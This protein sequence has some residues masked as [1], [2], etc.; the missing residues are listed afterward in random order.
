MICRTIALCLAAAPGVLAAPFTVNVAPLDGTGSCGRTTGLAS[1]LTPVAHAGSFTHINDGNP[2]TRVDTWAND[3]ADTHSAASVV[4]PLPRPD[5]LYSVE[6]TMACFADGG[7]FGPS[8][9]PGTGALLTAAHL[10]APVLQTST[11]GGVTWTTAATTDDYLAAVTGHSTGHST[12]GGAFPNPHPVT[13]R[14]DLN[15]PLTGINAVRLIGQH[16]GDPTAYLGI[17]EMVINAGPDK[18]N[19]GDTMEDAWEEIY[20]NP[21][22]LSQGS[23]F[24]EDAIP[25]EI[26]FRWNT[27][28]ASTD[29]DGDG[30]NDKSEITSGASSPVLAD[31]DGDSLPDGDELL[32]H[33]TNPRL[34][35]TD[36]DGLSDSDEVN[37]HLTS[38]TDT[39]TD[40]DGFTDHEEVCVFGTLPAV[41]DTDGDGFPDGLEYNG[42]SFLQPELFPGN[43]ARAG[44]AVL[45][46]N[47]AID[48]DHGTAV[49]NG[50][51]A[52]HV[53]DGD[54]NT[55]VNTGSTPSLT[56]YSYVG[57]TWPSAW[58]RPIARA[59]VHFA[60]ALDG[61]WFGPNALAPAPGSELSPAYLTEP[62]VQFTTDG[63][64]WQTYTGTV[65]SS[66]LSRL[67]GFAVPLGAIPVAREADFVFYPPISG[68]R[69][70][71]LIGRE[72]GTGNDG[73]LGVFEMQ[74]QD[75][76][77][78][79]ADFP[80][81]TDSDGDGTRDSEE[82]A[83]GTPIL[84]AAVNAGTYALADS[85]TAFSGVQGQNGW[86]YGY[87][88]YPAG[89]SADYHPVTGFIPFAGGSDVPV[90]Y[91]VASINNH[92]QHWNPFSGRW[93]LSSPATPGGEFAPWV[94]IDWTLA[95]PGSSNQFPQHYPA[96]WGKEL[97]VVRRWTAP[98]SIGGPTPVTIVYRSQTSN[99]T[100]T[101]GVTGALYINGILRDHVTLSAAGGDAAVRR[102]PTILQ[103]GDLV[104]LVLTPEGPDGDRR[105][106][107]DLTYHWMRI[108][109]STP[110][111]PPFRPHG[112][113]F[114]H[115]G[116]PDTDA[117]GLP[118]AWEKWWPP[119]SLTTFSSPGSDSDADGL[120]FAQEIAAG[121][122][123]L[124][125]DSDADGVPDAAEAAL[126]TSSITADSDADGRTDLQESTGSPATN[127]LLA[128][129]DGDGEWDGYE[130]RNAS[131]PASAGST[132]RTGLLADSTADFTPTQ[133][134]RNWHYGYRD[135]T[136]TGSTSNYNPATAFTQY[137]T[138]ALPGTSFV[139]Y[140]NSP[141]SALT[142]GPD[143]ICESYPS[144]ADVG[145][146][147][148]TI[149]RWRTEV[150][151]TTP[152]AVTW[153]MAKSGP[154][155]TGTTGGVFLNGHPVDL[156]LLG[157]Y[158][159]TGI[160]RRLYLNLQP[161][162]ILDLVQT[163]EGR[164]GDRSSTGDAAYFS[165][166]VDTRIPANPTQPN[167][168]PFIPAEVEP[169]VAEF[170][171]GASG[172]KF[173]ISWPVHPAVTYTVEQ[174]PAMEPGTWEPADVLD[175]DF[176][177]TPGR[178][179]A[180]IASP[181]S[182]RNFLRVTRALT[183]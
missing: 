156:V 6:F 9:G 126:G 24:D 182:Q 43:A 178:A 97:W 116:T 153:R 51:A 117:D 68:A 85:V 112:R 2:A 76:G 159:T 176:T 155:G 151:E 48:S 94:K 67:S 138:Y 16:G 161:G 55:R 180:V 41:R 63:S 81:I 95:H 109:S 100:G 92:T 44:T 40:D 89:G 142:S 52:A 82:Y 177:T 123:P 10:A 31:T 127:P 77:S 139:W 25:D 87:R 26:E 17:A 60:I 135:Y 175:L 61:G 83:C 75:T 125:A 107:G 119:H 106:L 80:D 20:T 3:P 1:P 152:V 157:A 146:E 66:Y 46:V 49:A 147:N 19:D 183:P 27:N 140:A 163:P 172:E 134:H 57:I 131:D 30:L 86:R 102:Y 34:T 74:V 84:D 14:F 164:C 71:R 144:G 54:T 171:P 29:T 168:G 181:G 47:D 158:D 148:W 136:A 108:L 37:L 129:S 78:I 162:D 22:N 15:P 18:D 103:P 35:D 96:F 105:D 149:R 98:A 36:A 4:W 93:N 111:I 53:N 88:H 174:S 113:F 169:F 79:V 167:G 28:P 42:G 122:S 179:T 70:I 145:G 56:G 90:P 104:D 137:A 121:T 33:G 23:D 58:P 115:S 120:T 160:T 72:G 166:R 170:V 7:W 143:S 13:F 69:G 132:S 110:H 32:I 130:I 45:G 73:Y 12:G 118:D 150:L 141:P 38:P 5:F 124:S 173:A 39:D 21:G 99:L 8:G 165:M 11:D 91:T 59:S 133:G 64:S 114:T 62:A 101:T 154:W 50:G 65:V 128:D